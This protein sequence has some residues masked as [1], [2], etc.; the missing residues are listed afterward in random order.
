MAVIPTSNCC[1]PT[2]AA[3]ERA[4]LLHCFPNF[5][6]GF[7]QYGDTPDIAGLIAPRRLHLNFGERDGGSP[8]AEVRAGV[9]TIRAAYAA[10]GA[11][12]ASVGR[13]T[14]SVTALDLGLDLEA[15]LGIDTVKQAELFAAVRENYGIPRRED[16]R[17][18]DYNTLSKVIG[19]V[20]ESQ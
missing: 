16:L 1:L 12:A 7:Q 18:I 17:L 2:Y 19:F 9:E 14:H 20:L 3:I 15:D 6:P 10:A 4:K 13:L 11:D 5:V 8:I